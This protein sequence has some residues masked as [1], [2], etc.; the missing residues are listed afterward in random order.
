MLASLLR[1]CVAEMIAASS[2]A[3]SSSSLVEA[4]FRFLRTRR[5]GGACQDSVTVAAGIGTSWT[6]DWWTAEGN[7]SS[8]CMSSATVQGVVP[9]STELSRTEGSRSAVCVAAETSITGESGSVCWYTSSC[10]RL[11]RGRPR[12]LSA[13]LEMMSPAFAPLCTA[14][15]QD[16]AD[17]PSFGS[18]S[19]GASL[20]RGASMRKPWDFLLLRHN[21]VR[22]S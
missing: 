10:S 3:S 16:A 19:L 5:R 18:G 13:R 2:K 20:L 12:R 15:A 6:G 11:V 9:V 17:E 4:M 7:G 1:S 14:A 8:V 21:G 22:N